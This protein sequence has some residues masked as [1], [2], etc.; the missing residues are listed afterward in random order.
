MAFTRNENGEAWGR[1]LELKDS[2]GREH[3]WAMPMRLLSG[4]G[5]EYRATLLDMGLLI[6]PGHKAR[7]RLTIYLQTAK[8][9]AWARCVDRTGWYGS[10]FVLPDE[11]IGGMSGERVLLQAASGGHRAYRQS[12]A[13]EDWQR[14]VA[15]LC[16]GNSR[17]INAAL[18]ARHHRLV[19]E[20]R[21][22]RLL[23]GGKKRISINVE[24]GAGKGR[25]GKRELAHISIS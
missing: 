10:A 20:G 22:A 24:D 6:A 9:K 2:E 1:L 14:D 13:L 19:L 25:D 12:G 3:V 18:L 15:A 23:A 21:I 17:L 8:P 4:D 11:T 5:N 16:V 7:E